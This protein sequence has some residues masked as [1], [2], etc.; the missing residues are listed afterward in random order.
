MK[1]LG[2][3]AARSDMLSSSCLPDLDDGAGLDISVL[4]CSSF[5]VEIAISAYNKVCL[6]TSSKND[7]QLSLKTLQIAY[8]IYDITF[9]KRLLENT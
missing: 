6:E 2:R 8:C 5:S 1:Y 3:G 7:H 9:S 4:L